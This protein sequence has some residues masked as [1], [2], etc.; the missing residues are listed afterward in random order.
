MQRLLLCILALMLLALAFSGCNGTSTN[1]IVSITGKDDVSGTWQ[2]D[3]TRYVISA[4]DVVTYA[5]MV[6]STWKQVDDALLQGGTVAKALNTVTVSFPTLTGGENVFT[7]SSGM[8]GHL[9]IT[10]NQS[11]PMDTGCMRVSN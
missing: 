7:Y 8:D 6:D 10:Q 1:S 5:R 11:E 3:S 9:Y 4:S 2:N